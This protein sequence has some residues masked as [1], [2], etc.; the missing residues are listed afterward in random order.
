MDL[1]KAAGSR[2]ARLAKDKRADGRARVLRVAKAC[3]GERWGG[4]E[5]GGGNG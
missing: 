2:R 4:D 3:R 5:Q 1:G